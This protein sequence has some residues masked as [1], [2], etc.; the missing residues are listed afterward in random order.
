MGQKKIS[1]MEDVI[2]CI[3]DR[4]VHKKEFNDV[5]G[6]LQ[7]VEE[8]LDFLPVD[9]LE[10]SYSRILKECPIILRLL[11]ELV[12][13]NEISKEKYLIFSGTVVMSLIEMYCDVRKCILEVCEE[14]ELGSE[15]DVE[16]VDDEEMLDYSISNISDINNIYIKEIMQYKVLTSEEERA[17]F[18]ALKNG[19]LTAREKIINANFRLVLKYARLF[20]YSGADINDLIQEGNI[21]LMRATMDYDPYYG[22]KFST[23]A[24]PWILHKIRR[25]IQRNNRICIPV[26]VKEQINKYKMIKLSFASSLGREPTLSELVEELDLTSEQVIEVKTL[27]ENEPISLNTLISGEENDGIELE[28]FANADTTDVTYEEAEQN[29]FKAAIYKLI[30]DSNLTPTESDVILLRYG[31]NSPIEKE[32]TLEEIGR[33]K[34]ITRERVRQIEEKAINKLSLNFQMLQFTCFA[35]NPDLAERKLDIR[36]LIQFSPFSEKYPTIYSYFPEYTE[37]EINEAVLYLNSADK[38]LL[39]RVCELYNISQN[40]NWYTNS[41]KIRLF[42]VI[43]IVYDKLIKKYGK[44]PFI[45]SK[46]TVYQANKDVKNVKRLNLEV[47][48]LNTDKKQI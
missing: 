17:L 44:R 39:I 27:A 5:I 10:I 37:L 41:M 33:L 7:K 13:D 47:S 40:N 20:R 35:D 22:T 16:I 12:E 45:N 46:E 21:G 29:S 8:I 19:D 30:M 24:T 25:Y 3:N 32:M 11:D 4:I 38:E 31:I 9:V 48:K 18:I 43:G 42:K 28:V 6:E 15:C 1:T 26:H 23:Y 36:H 2:N 34:G 14:D